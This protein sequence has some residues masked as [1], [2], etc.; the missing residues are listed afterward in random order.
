MEL[1][2]K[3]FGEGQPLLILH[4]LF[5][6]SDNWLTLG[7]KLAEQYK[8]YLIDQRNHGRSPW[9]N[10]WDYQLMAED[11]LK[12]V[13]THQLD[14]FILVGHSMGGKT[15]MN[16]AARYYPSKIQK[17]VVV[18]IAPK[19]Y[20]IHHD[21]IVAGLR[22]LDLG[23]IN[24]RKE[25][26]EQLANYVEEVGV[27]QF[28]LKNL[29]RPKAEESAKK[30]DWRIN[31]QVIGDNLDKMSVGLPENFEFEK[32]TLFIRGLR[33]NYIK[34]GDEAVIQRYFLNAVIH[35]VAEA[36][37]WVH[38][39]KPQEFLDTLLEFIQS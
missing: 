27:R 10:D 36:G 17:L 19:S 4:G 15:A 14:D 11:L 5:G 37:H 34:D 38:A 2:Y 20:P 7:R 18:D 30:F 16:Y 3:T 31:L 29:Y 23:Q 32:P 33:S 22:A 12:F 25:A 9:S 35:S 13:Q 21:Q 6:S 39:E 26:D 24:S 1:H 28:L 8:V